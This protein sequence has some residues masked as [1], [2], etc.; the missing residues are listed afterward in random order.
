[1]ITVDE[2]QLT[3]F[4]CFSYAAEIL[5]RVDRIE[6]NDVAKM[7]GPGCEDRW[8]PRFSERVDC[9]QHAATIGS[10]R[11]GDSLR[12]A[13]TIGADL[14]HELRSHEPNRAVKQCLR[15]LGH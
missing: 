6:A 8:H 7:S 2:D 3:A 1:M 15:M 4:P 11:P 14:D 9:V 5:H 12:G 13:G 10:K